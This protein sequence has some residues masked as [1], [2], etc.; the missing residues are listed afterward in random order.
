MH[1]D[2]PGFS[3]AE[4]LIY[5]CA[6]RCSLDRLS[7]TLLGITAVVGLVAGIVTLLGH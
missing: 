4:A 1:V 7:T 3:P 5:L 2:T 6:S